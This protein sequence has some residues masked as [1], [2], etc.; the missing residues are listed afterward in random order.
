MNG[1]AYV[2]PCVGAL[3]RVV[4]P[5][6]E[7]PEGFA[8]RRRQRDKADSHLGRS[9]AQ[10]ILWDWSNNTREYDEAVVRVYTPAHTRDLPKQQF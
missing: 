10:S 1:S 7:N 9:A 2:S 3:W 8:C 4:T 6:F 5:Q